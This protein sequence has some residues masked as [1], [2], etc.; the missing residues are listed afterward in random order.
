MKLILTIFQLLLIATI[1]DF[2]IAD[3][4]YTTPMSDPADETAAPK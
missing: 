3:P 2:A 1:L 4:M